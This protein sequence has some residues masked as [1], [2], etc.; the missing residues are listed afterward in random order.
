GHRL[1]ALSAHGHV[2]LPPF[3]SRDVRR[4]AESMAGPLPEPAVAVIEELAQGSPFMATAALQGLVES[5][6]LVPGAEGWRVEPVA[7]ADVQSS[8]HAAAFLARRMELL[9][10][11]V[12]A[13]LSAG[14]VL[15]KE[16]DLDFAA[17]LAEQ[18]PAAA[19]TALDEARRR[20]IVWAKA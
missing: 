19:V 8:R 15:G 4:L 14:A 18:A 11:A 6:A 5:G 2:R 3:Q 1:R 9:P 10:P 13:L 17:T 7:V 12:V 16:F 20:H